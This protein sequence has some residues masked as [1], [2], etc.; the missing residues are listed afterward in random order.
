MSIVEMTSTAVHYITEDVL[1]GSSM[2]AKLPV[3]IM[4]VFIDRMSRGPPKMRWLNISGVI[5]QTSA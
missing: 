1:L 5:E 3:A 2:T 4:Y